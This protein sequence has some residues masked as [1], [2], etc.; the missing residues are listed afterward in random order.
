MNTTYGILLT[1]RINSPQYRHFSPLSLTHTLLS[2]SLSLCVCGVCVRE[3]ER[4]KDMNE[5]SKH[6]SLRLPNH[7][8]LRSL[9]IAHLMEFGRKETIVNLQI[10]NVWIRT[11]HQERKREREREEREERERDL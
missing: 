1:E 11:K 6:I 5:T 3:R 7:Y 9:V 8:I 4:M 2:L 10:Q